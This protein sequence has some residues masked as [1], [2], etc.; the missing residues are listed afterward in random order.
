MSNFLGSVAAHINSSSIISGGELLAREGLHLQHSMY[1]RPE[2]HSVFLVLPK[3]GTYS[4]KWDPQ[5]GVYAFCGHDSLHAEGGGSED[6][7]AMYASGK[8]SQNGKFLKAALAAASGEHSPITVQIYEKLEAGAYFDKGLFE[9][10]GARE[11]KEDGRLVYVFMLRP[12][13]E[14][15]FERMLSAEQKVALWQAACGRCSQ[16]GNEAGLRFVLQGDSIELLC[17]PHRGEGGGLLG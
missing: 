1:Y 8:L 10:I 7:R 16:C 6:Q 14:P 9:L 4:E 3:E 12:I 2:G 11:S 15:G 17:A 5:S 13:G